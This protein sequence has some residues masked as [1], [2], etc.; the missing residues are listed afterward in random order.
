MLVMEDRSFSLLGEGNEKHKKTVLTA[1]FGFL[2]R[3]T[4]GDDLFF[5]WKRKEQSSHKMKFCHG[6][7]FNYSLK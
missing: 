7:S 4:F 1:S 5:S 2:V 6:L 3:T